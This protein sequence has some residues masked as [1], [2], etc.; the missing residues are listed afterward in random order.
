MIEEG[1]RD[2]SVLV[3]DVSVDGRSDLE[4]RRRDN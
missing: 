1:M 3:M 4:R 2:A